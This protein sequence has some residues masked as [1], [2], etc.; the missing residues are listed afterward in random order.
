MTTFTADMPDTESSFASVRPLRTATSGAP[1]D[2]MLQGIEVLGSASIQHGA[3]L[4]VMREVLLALCA[5]L[6]VTDRAGVERALRQGIENMFVVTEDQ[7]ITG[8]F[9]NMVLREF[10]TY[11]SRL[12]GTPISQ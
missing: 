8:S 4:L 6:P 5:R 12:R 7:P 11:L 2:G 9:Y 3:H 10:N 1:D